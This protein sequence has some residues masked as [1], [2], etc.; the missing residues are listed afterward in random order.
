MLETTII[1]TDKSKNKTMIETSSATPPIRNGGTR[2][3]SALTGGSVTINSGSASTINQRGG[4][5]WREK[6]WIISMMIR[7]IR[8]HE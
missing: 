5:N 6:D 2:R 4:L 1:K 8:I 7:A 3:R